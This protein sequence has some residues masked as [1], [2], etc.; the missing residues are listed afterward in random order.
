L[1]TIGIHTERRDEARNL[2]SRKSREINMDY[3]KRLKN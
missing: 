2:M 3:E 1:E